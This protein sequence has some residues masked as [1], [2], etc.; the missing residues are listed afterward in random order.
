MSR[1]Y[2]G[3]AMILKRVALVALALLAAA[4]VCDYLWVRYKVANPKAGDP[5]GSVTFYD[6]T[7]MKNGKVEV[8]YDQ[9]QTQACVRAIFP[10]YGDQPC[11]YAGRKTVKSID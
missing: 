1:S 3:E 11:W 10:H 7:T 2:A 9:P 4:Y 6:S 8:F 5:F